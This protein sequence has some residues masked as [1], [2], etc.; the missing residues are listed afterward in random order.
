MT[1]RPTRDRCTVSGLALLA[2]LGFAAG[3]RPAV[4]AADG[5][6]PDAT[7]LSEIV[8]TA[9]RRSATALSTPINIS[10]ISGADLAKE[11]VSDFRSLSRVTP[12]LVY[13]GTSIRNGG[14]TNSFVL[15]GLNLDDVSNS[16]DAPLPTV[17]PVSV[18]IGETPAFV[19]LHLADVQRVEVLRGPQATL[20]GD[21]SI[22]GTVRIL[23]NEPDPTK[24]AGEISGGG[25]WTRNAN[26]PNYTL[27]GVINVPIT[28]DSALR[29]AGGYVFENGFI[30]APYLFALNAQGIPLLANPGDVVHS[31]PLS[32]SKT[33]IDNSDLGYVRPMFLYKKDAF[34]L[35]ITYQ[36]QHEH[37]DGDD[38]DSYPGGP[39]PTS[40][41]STLTP[42]FQNNGFDAAFPSTFKPYQSGVFLPSPYARDVH[43]VSVE[44]AYDFGFATLTAV[45]SYFDNNSV[46]QTDN[47]GFYEASL[48]FLY[49]GYPRL[50]LDSH[51]DFNDDALIE[52]VRLVSKSS[53]K[54]T[55][56]VGAFYMNED[57]HYLQMDDIPG[58]TAY[59]AALGA[60]T[61]TDLAYRYERR[62]H[63]FDLAG[64]GQATY[65]VTSRWQVTGGARVYQQT[66]ALDS[67]IEL[68]ICGVACSDD[69]VSP[70]GLSGGGNKQV[71][72]NVL[73]NFNTSYQLTHDLL[74]F[75]TF[76]QGERRGGAN[77]VPTKGVLGASPAFLF[78]KPDTV[79]NYEV[80]LKGKVGRDFQFSSAF[81][82]V[83]WHN[84]QVNV[85]TPVGAFPA[86]VNGVAARSQGVDLDA[87]YRVI[88]SVTLSATYSYNHSQLLDPIEVG[89]VSYGAAGTRLP[90]TPQHTVSLGGDYDHALT[91][92]LDFNG[93][94][95]VSYRSDMTTSLTPSLDEDLTGFAIVNASAGV[96]HGPWRLGLFVDNLTNTRGVVSANPIGPFGSGPYDARSM[97]NRLSRPLTAGL[98]FGYKFE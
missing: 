13:N 95:D 53:G 76:S 21:A 29:V 86:V 10:A 98:R 80:G 96:S 70:L 11:G 89:G 57:N 38:I 36:Y 66:L 31:L 44:A 71:N 45:T 64:F 15:H 19:N 97:N 47:S 8:V 82:W 34:K 79:D 20:Y 77:G 16:G 32:T 6:A 46:A 59:S 60:P 2:A 93:H 43:L 4:A 87:R 54:L 52:E 69:G 88:E 35:L 9:S 48:G 73:M 56:S 42:G 50:S 40:Y 90:G 28:S 55:Y 41:S 51:R 92:R 30:N 67:T 91:D 18:Y 25:G 39:A 85:S 61:G 33:N 5:A 17:A 1:T 68:P 24:L 49:S 65:H 3:A 58:F 62:F 37:A 12:G 23:P 78:F 74:A 26:A 94:V 81:Y 27:D 83:E 72:N 7:S 84:P 63:F 75:A 22:A 14:A